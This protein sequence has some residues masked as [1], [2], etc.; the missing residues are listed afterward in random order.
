MTTEVLQHVDI[1]DIYTI[2]LAA[3][4]F[5][6]AIHKQVYKRQHGICAGC[7]ECFP[8]LETHHVLPHVLGG[9]DTI[10]NALGL[11]GIGDNGCHQKADDMAIKEGIIFP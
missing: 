9:P 8:K 2:G 1:V 4:A 3:M 11:C 5:S 7:E 10:D 6:K